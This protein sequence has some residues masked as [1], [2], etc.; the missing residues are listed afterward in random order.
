MPRLRRLFILVSTLGY[1]FLGGG[2][3]LWALGLNAPADSR[4][5]AIGCTCKMGQPGSQCH[6]PFMMALMRRH[7]GLAG[8]QPLHASCEMRQRPLAPE[9]S[10][11]AQ[12]SLPSQQPHT[13]PSAGF[14]LRLAQGRS[15]QFPAPCGLLFH[16]EPPTPIPD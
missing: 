15:S 10:A 3:S 13:L 7:P 1:A 5:A 9:Q 6:C 16:P 2:P 8:A 4:C 12:H 11:D 14:D